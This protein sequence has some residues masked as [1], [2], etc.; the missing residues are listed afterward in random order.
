[1]KTYLVLGGYG[2]MGRIASRDLAETAKG[3]RIIIA[4]RDEGK[5][6]QYAK[7][8]KRKN[9]VGIAADATKTGDLVAMLK[10]NKVDVVVNCTLYYYNLHIMQACLKAGC[11]YLDL[12]G[13]FHMTKKQ[14][15]LNQKFKKKNLVAILGC[16]ST[17]GITNVMA[18]YGVKMLDKVREIHVRFAGYS[19]VPQK[20]HFV[21]PYSMYT[22]FDEFTARP[23]VFTKGRMKFVKPISGRAEEYFP[24]PI[25]KVTTFYT[26]HS[27]LATFPSSFKKKGIKECSFKVSFDEDFV[28]DV[29]LLIE[30]GLAS[31][32]MVK[33]GKAKIRPVDL[34]VKEL[35][36]FVPDNKN[37]EDIEYVR[38]IIKGEKRKKP[39][40]FILD[41]LAHSSKKW[42]AAAGDIDTGVP[43]SIIAQMIANGKIKQRGALPPEL[44][45]PAEMFFRELE[46][47]DMKIMM[48]VKKM[49]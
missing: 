36:R 23:A 9:V 46:K 47:R 8:L 3:A 49:E 31:K 17:P 37:V 30:S 10:K 42:R 1:M 34:T 35:N 25:N 27:E 5:A 29:K 32:K 33:I 40:E 21:V 24:D 14:L 19:F 7:S 4:G 38:V 11:H 18:G 39:A 48:T 15:K 28:H 44:C 6:K 26:L 41:C 2:E 12:G 20:R 43:P 22:V 16:G 45:V 13:L